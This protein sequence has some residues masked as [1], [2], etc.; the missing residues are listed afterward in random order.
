M[1][2]SLTLGLISCTLA[3]YMR[4]FKMQVHSLYYIKSV[5]LTLSAGLSWRIHWQEF[6][7]YFADAIL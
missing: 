2:A 1:V 7:Q 3:P 5:Y 6:C 4:I